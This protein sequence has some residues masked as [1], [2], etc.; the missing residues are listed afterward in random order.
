MTVPP[1]AGVEKGQTAATPQ[2]TTLALVGMVRIM[3]TGLAQIL[4]MPVAEV[5]GP[6]W[7]VPSVPAGAEWAEVVLQYQLRPPAQR[8]A[9]D[10]AAAAGLKAMPAPLEPTVLLLFAINKTEAES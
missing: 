1:P 10:Q 5:V 9:Q 8:P 3:L 4:C 7:V 2:A 6:P